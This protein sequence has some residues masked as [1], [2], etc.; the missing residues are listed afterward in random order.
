MFFLF[1]LL[2]LF[3]RFGD[4]IYCFSIRLWILLDIFVSVFNTPMLLKS[5]FIFLLGFL[6]SFLNTASD[7]FSFIF[8]FLFFF[9][10]FMCWWQQTRSFIFII[11]F[12]HFFGVFNN[13][14]FFKLCCVFQCLLLLFLLL[15]SH[16]CIFA[17]FWMLLNLFGSFFRLNLLFFMLFF[18]SSFWFLNSSFLHFTFFFKFGFLMF[19]FFLVGIFTSKLVWT[20]LFRD[21]FVTFFNI[22][23]VK[24]LFF[25][26]LFIW[27]FSFLI[28]FLWGLLW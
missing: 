1:I 24:I 21:C 19:I 14:G 28:R 15:L 2:F 22:E 18:N 9:L 6:P 11:L 20:R 12:L 10:I 3:Y 4:F 27:M 25:I 5:I 13:I 8:I 26:L 17:N 7:L 23:S 16:L